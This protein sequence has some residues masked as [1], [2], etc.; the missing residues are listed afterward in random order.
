VYADRIEQTVRAEIEPVL[1]AMGYSLVELS[2]GRRRGVTHVVVVLHRPG[3]VGVDQ[4]AE[5]TRAVR[6]RLELVEGLADVTLEVSSPGIERTLK[7][8]SEYAIFRGRGVRVLPAGDGEWVG[9]V[10]EAFR[11]GTLVLRTP[12][13]AR[14]FP[15]GAVRRA[16]LDYRLD[17]ESPKARG[18][19]GDRPPNER[20]DSSGERSHA[21]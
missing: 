8:P 15:P 1:A 18:T 3:G 16:R 11:D 20:T 19:P 17:P 12:A 4:C 9:G 6:P 2:V 5:V 21:V 7:D 14:E 13:G 10:I